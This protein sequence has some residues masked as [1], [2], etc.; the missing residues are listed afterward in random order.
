MAYEL[1]AP[2]AAQSNTRLKILL[3]ITASLLILTLASAAYFIHP[4]SRA[5]KNPPLPEIIT[6]QTSFP[7]Y[8]FVGAPP[9]SMKLDPTSVSYSTGLLIFK[10]HSADGSKT[11]TV[12]EQA[13]PPNLENTTVQGKEKIDGADGNATLGF[14]GTRTI[15]YL[16]NK[17]KKT[18]VIIN[19]SSA[20][21][22]TI[23]D[24][25][26]GLRPLNK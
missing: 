17:D 5:P 24:L 22:D 13:L 9:D 3:A 4:W 2:V 23:K 21:T 26:R 25:L 12:T 14:D 18:F 7:V 8:Y 11:V 1:H 16:L 15:G 10:L 19:A 6:A 20:E